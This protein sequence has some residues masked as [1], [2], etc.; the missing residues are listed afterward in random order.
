VSIVR[1]NIR[2]RRIDDV[3]YDF[4]RLIWNWNPQ[5]PDAVKEAILDELDN[6]LREIRRWTEKHSQ[7]FPEEVKFFKAEDNSPIAKRRTA[8]LSR[9]F[10]GMD[11]WKHSLDSWGPVV[12]KKN[13][14][15][16]DRSEHL[17]IFY[18]H[19]VWRPFETKID[20]KKTA[21]RIIETQCKNWPQMKFQFACCYALTDLLEDDYLFDKCR[22][23]AFKKNLDGHPVYS[24]WLRVLENCHE[25]GRLYRSD[26]VLVDQTLMLVFR[27]AIINGFL[28]L[29]K[30][31][32]IGLSE[33]QMEAVGFLCW[34]KIC[35]SAEHSDMIAFLC[36]ILC[37]INVKGMIRLTWDSFYDK[38]YTMLQDCKIEDQVENFR[39]LELLLNNWCPS[40]RAGIL[41]RDN[42][43]VLVDSVMHNKPETFEFFLDYIEKKALTSISPRI[44]EILEKRKERNKETK[45]DF[46]RFKESL[47]RRQMTFH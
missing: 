7:I 32:W 31:L 37:R 13:E 34:K 35:F 20:D 47:L 21:E 5:I 16:L 29:V 38:V 8:F 2:W 18:D 22:R 33:P 10:T 41:C 6:A 25:M 39:K 1:A 45:R 36:Q 46:K 44:K 11:S 24:F 43:K 23:K 42:F 27:F 15:V 12:M 28:E 4:K 9:G 40:L 17:R 30:H 26:R 14:R 3:S 19:L